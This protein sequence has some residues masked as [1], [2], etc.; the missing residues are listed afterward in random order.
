MDIPANIPLVTIVTITHNRANLIGRAIAS[1]L[2]Q[3]YKNIEYII[4]DAASSDE[5]PEVIKNFNDDRIHYIRLKENLSPAVSIN[6]G[7]QRAQGE[8]LCFLDDDDEYCPNR[9]EKAVEKFA[10]LDASY[11]LVYCWM[12][13][14]D[15]KTGKVDHVH[16]PKLRGYVG[17]E[18]VESPEKSVSGTPTFTFRR[19]VFLELKGWRN[20]IGIISDWE[21]AARLCQ[22]WKVDF[23]PESLVNVYIN[24]GLLRMSDS[25]FY[26]DLAPKKIT[27][28]QHFLD[29]FSHVFEKYP[30]RAYPHY[31]SLFRNNLILRKWKLSWKN[32]IIC[33]RL[34]PSF[35]LIALWPYILI[36]N[37]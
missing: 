1:I 8:F 20:D 6:L 7:A 11:G 32:W 33:F 25:N 5:T 24:H 30:N 23:I 9:I 28:A 15:S 19:H 34:K 22:K 27:F 17:D 10:E 26:K 14:F 21:L 2:G 18:V 35:R 29:E 16:A 31:E 13:Y 37:R 36:T 3:T 4:V 12:T